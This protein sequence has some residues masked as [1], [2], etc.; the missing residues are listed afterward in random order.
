MKHWKAE[1]ELAKLPPQK[2][3]GQRLRAR[4]FGLGRELERWAKVDSFEL[5]KFPKRQAERSGAL[6]GLLL[7][8]AACTGLCAMLY[9]VTGPTDTFAEGDG[10]GD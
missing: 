1:T 5:P 4:D 8:A 3:R 2:A 9:Q 6:V 7:V 10:P